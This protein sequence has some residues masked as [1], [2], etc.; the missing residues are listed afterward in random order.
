ML[1]VHLKGWADK[2]AVQKIFLAVNII[3]TDSFLT[4]PATDYK[5]TLFIYCLKNV[6]LH[7]T[8][9]IVTESKSPHHTKNNCHTLTSYIATRMY[10]T[11]TH[12]ANTCTYTHRCSL[13]CLDTL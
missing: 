6:I 12:V 13:I 7:V 11:I 3:S 10:C 4:I 9:K 5:F 1:D 2:T 8:G